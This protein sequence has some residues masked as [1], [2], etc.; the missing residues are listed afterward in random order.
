[1]N[2]DAQ[3]IIP[4]DWLCPHASSAQGCICA[5]LTAPTACGTSFCV[6]FLRF[7]AAK[8]TYYGGRFA[9]YG[10]PMNAQSPEVFQ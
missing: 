2:N 4:A 9:A 8:A 7:V 10:V 5:P 1:M 6:N 3:D